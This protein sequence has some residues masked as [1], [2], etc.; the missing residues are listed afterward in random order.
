MRPGKSTLGPA[1]AAVL[2]CCSLQS[3]VGE[4]CPRE[5][6]SARRVCDDACGDDELCSQQ[7]DVESEICLAEC[8]E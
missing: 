3:D 7:C 5:C 6:E 8:S 4:G 2:T 1:L